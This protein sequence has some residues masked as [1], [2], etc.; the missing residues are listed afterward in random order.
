M[1]LG[2]L[3]SVS[4]LPSVFILG[5]RA[6]LAQI[7]LVGI[8]PGGRGAWGS[9]EQQRLVGGTTGVHEARDDL[10]PL[11][12]LVFRLRLMRPR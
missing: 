6:H 2:V 9:T 3:P 12:T 1:G 11:H 8:C 7:P 5:P 10:E 4:P